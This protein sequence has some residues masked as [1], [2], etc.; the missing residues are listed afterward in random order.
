VAVGVASSCVVTGGG[1]PA[2]GSLQAVM[3]TASIPRRIKVQMSF[4]FMVASLK[5][6][7]QFLALIFY[8]ILP[9]SLVGFILARHAGCIS[10]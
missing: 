4:L 6:G 1:L 8:I 9:I 2:A 7:A 3:V 10:G 5:P